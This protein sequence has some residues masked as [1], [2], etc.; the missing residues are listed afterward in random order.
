M[1]ENTLDTQE[2]GEKVVNVLKTIFD[3][4][5]PVDIYELG[6]KFR[7]HEA[8]ELIALL[9]FVINKRI[10]ERNAMPF[11]KHYFFSNIF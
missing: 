7:V 10:Y 2:L 4:E 8:F 6:L 11:L 3:P 5:I 9:S 1:S